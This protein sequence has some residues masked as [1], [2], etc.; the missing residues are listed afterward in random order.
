ML[1]LD[2]FLFVKDKSARNKAYW[3]RQNFAKCCKCRAVTA[4]DELTSVSRMTFNKGTKKYRDIA[5]HHKHLL[6]IMLT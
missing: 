2:G 5:T 6:K 4:D 3:K 1:Y